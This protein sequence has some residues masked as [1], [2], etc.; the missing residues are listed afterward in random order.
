M[1]TFA[2]VVRVNERLRQLADA[3]LDHEELRWEALGMLRRIVPVVGWSWAVADPASAIAVSALSEHP[4]GPAVL[5]LLAIEEDEQELNRRTTLAAARHHV[6]TL[7]QATGGDL[8]RSRRWREHLHGHGIGDELRVVFAD[9]TGCWGYL[10]LYT[11]EGARYTDTDA[12][13]GQTI[14]R[15]LTPALRRCHAFPA[16]VDRPEPP[17]EPGVLILDERLTVLGRTAAADHWLRQLRWVP[18][19]PLPC[20]ITATSI[21]A[22]AGDAATA[23]ARQ[24]DRT[25]QLTT[26]TAARLDNGGVGVTVV[27]SPPHEVLTFVARATALSSREQQLLTLLYQGYDTRLI[28]RRL[29]IAESTTLDHMKAILSK[30]GHTSR[31]SLLASLGQGQK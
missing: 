14:A 31:L 1:T 24:R 12:E 26:V 29:R 13:I 2:Q 4:F 20:A 27:Q 16:P 8:Y 17:A 6:A 10:D 19:E 11:E 22:L 23:T 15:L 21:R 9:H 30:T 3:R 5:D 25:G 18:A 28:A 7:G